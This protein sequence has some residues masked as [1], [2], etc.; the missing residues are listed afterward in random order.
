MYVSTYK[1]DMPVGRGFEWTPTDNGKFKRRMMAPPTFSVA[2]VQWMDFMS[3]DPRFVDKNGVRQKIQH[4]W[5]NKEVSI[6]KYQV[7]G[8]VK[9]DNK[10]YILEFDGCYWHGCSICLTAAKS[11]DKARD[12]FLGHHGEIIRMLGC[13]WARKLRSGRLPE[14]KIS[15]FL[16]MN[17]PITE[18][19]I[20][21]NIKN[22]TVTGFVVV[23]IEPTEAAKKYERLN[24]P[25]IF[26]RDEIQHAD[27]PPWLQ[28]ETRAQSFPRK[29]L[30]QTMRATEILLHTALLKFY[31]DNGFVVT[32]IYKFIEFQPS[33]CFKDFHDKLYRL[34]V[35]AT[36]QN[37][38]E[39]AAATKLTGNAV[40][41]KVS[42]NLKFILDRFRKFKIDFVNPR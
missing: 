35:E 41:G 20:L 6:G 37:N 28:S 27:L 26:V 29:T 19:Q 2:C 33:K 32:K 22:G 31:L 23:D 4:A 30:V 21:S 15:P 11:N 24:W 9:V 34:R 8:Y 36:L 14:P 1:E 16:F 13:V 7:D 42:L 3:N 38:Q 5:S 17:K 18:E 40:Y 10:V 12:A 39:M 25:P